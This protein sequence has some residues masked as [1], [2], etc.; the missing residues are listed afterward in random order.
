[1]RLVSLLSDGELIRNNTKHI[2]PYIS[3]TY[4][5]HRVWVDIQ[6]TTPTRYCQQKSHNLLTD[7]QVR[8]PLLFLRK[9]KAPEYYSEALKID[10]KKNLLQEGHLLGF[11]PRTSLKFV[12]VH[13]GRDLFTMVISAIPNSIVASRRKLFVY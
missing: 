3:I 1:M 13:T 7:N 4:N 5:F 11:C 10:G 12:E 8:Q 6:N 2:K 9:Q